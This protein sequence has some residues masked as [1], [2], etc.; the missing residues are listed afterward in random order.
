VTF[1]VRPRAA[2]RL[3]R[4]AKQFARPALESKGGRVRSS[5]ALCGR[6]SW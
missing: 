4:G 2:R 5:T 6:F 1:E 3:E